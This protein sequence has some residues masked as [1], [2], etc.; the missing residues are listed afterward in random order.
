MLLSS[1]G[2]RLF[3]GFAVLVFSA[4]SAC[5]YPGEA[6]AEACQL[7]NKEN[8]KSFKVF[9]IMGYRDIPD[10]GPYCIEKLKIWYGPEFWPDGVPRKDDFDLGLPDRNRVE[11]VAQRSPEF[12]G[13]TV[14]DIEHWPV[15]DETFAEAAVDNYLTVLDWFRRSAPSDQQVGYYSMLPIRD[16]WRAVR[17]KDDRKYKA[18]QEENDRLV[19]LADAVDIVFPS[20]YTFYED[21]EGWLNYAKAQIDESRRIAPD[22]KVYAFLWPEYHP[23]NRTRSGDPIEPDYW[24]EQLEFLKE[25]ADGVVIWTIGQTKAINFADIPPWWG[26]TVRFIED[27][28]TCEGCS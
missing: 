20:I 16:Y 15:E 10:L 12:G 26:E 2:R 4:I 22:K 8:G 24:R 21:Q 27:G 7:L 28:F 25:H 3:T 11:G 6:R 17:G 9:H 1:T 14:L 13:T 23:S 5:S 18:W 19:A